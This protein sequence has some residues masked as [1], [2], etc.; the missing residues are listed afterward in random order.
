MNGIYIY[1]RI[2]V[3]EEVDRSAK[4]HRL[5]ERFRRR[6]VCILSRRARDVRR[7]QSGTTVTIADVRGERRRKIEGRRATHQD[8]GNRKKER[9][10]SESVTCTCVP[11]GACTCV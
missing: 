11:C 4:D 7:R 6:E 5:V 1:T 8:G 9:C 10:V 3:R 2:G